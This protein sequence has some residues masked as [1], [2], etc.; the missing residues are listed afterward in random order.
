MKKPQSI[1]PVM[2]EG[3]LCLRYYYNRKPRY[4]RVANPN[5]ID[6]EISQLRAWLIIGEGLPPRKTPEPKPEP[7]PKKESTTDIETIL[8][9]WHE[10]ILTGAKAKQADRLSWRWR[11]GSEHG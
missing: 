10:E 11:C 6:T 1:K 9:T 8:A 4:K 3:N 5:N 7:E 2:H